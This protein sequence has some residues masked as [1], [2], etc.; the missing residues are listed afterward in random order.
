MSNE[1]DREK[2]YGLLKGFN[3]VVL[4]THLG[5]RLDARP[6]AVAR[7]EPDCDLWFITGAD[8]DKAREIAENPRVHV[9]AQHERDT[10]VS[11]AG[12]ARL[13]HDPAKI[14]ELWKEPYRVWFPDGPEDPNIRLIHLAA[15]AGEFWDNAG[16][17]KAKY[18][19]QAAKA[20]ATGSTPKVNEGDQHGE[21]KL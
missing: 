15:E 12:T 10:F 7:V 5:E 21:M 3:A 6:M 14:R 13:L 8:T 20:Y 1:T 19:L 9:V 4:I 2:F 17:N 11:L 16:A 18:L